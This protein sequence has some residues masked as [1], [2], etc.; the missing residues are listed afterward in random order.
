M[1]SVSHKNQQK[2]WNQEHA[3]PFVLKQMDSSDPSSGITR[4]LEF[5]KNTVGSVSGLKGIELGCGK[6]RNV[7]WLSKKGIS[8]TGIDFS[9]TAIKEAKKRADYAHAASTL[10]VHDATTRWPFASN[11]FDIAIDCFATT[12]IESEKGRQFAV[13]EMIRVVKPSGYILV[14]VMST[15][16]EFHKKMLKESPADEKN[17]FI[18]P[19]N[20]KFEKIYDREEILLLYKRLKLVAEERLAKTAVFFG[21][22]YACNH[23]WMIFKK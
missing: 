14:Y 10:V 4:F 13:N 8:M 21:K 2:I 5:L 16:D 18:H 7:I 20:G 3:H 15:D 19:T 23:Y 11:A 9:V 17:A 1:V 12:D 6:G 22:K